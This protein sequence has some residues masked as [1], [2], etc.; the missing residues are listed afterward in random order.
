MSYDNVSEHF[1][2][3][4]I[5][6]LIVCSAVVSDDPMPHIET[7]HVDPGEQSEAGTS[8]FLSEAH[9]VSPASKDGSD[10]GECH[11]GGEEGTEAGLG[12]PDAELV[13][14]VVQIGL[15]LYL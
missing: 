13:V 11:E 15:L 2:V 8:V 14:V 3:L 12:L 9:A 10:G 6:L 4:G 5:V 7:A 1:D